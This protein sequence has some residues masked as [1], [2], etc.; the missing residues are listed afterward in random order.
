MTTQDKLPCSGNDSGMPAESSQQ[1][2]LP[3]A[4]SITVGMVG[5][6]PRRRHQ[7]PDKIAKFNDAL[8]RLQARDCKPQAI[9][10]HLAK[11][12]F[13]YSRQ[14]VERWLA[15]DG[16]ASF[17]R[18]HEVYLAVLELA[19][20]VGTGPTKMVPPAQTYASQ[21]QSDVGSPDSRVAKII[22]AGVPMGAELLERIGNIPGLQYPELE[23]A[24]FYNRDEL[25]PI[26]ESPLVRE[27]AIRLARSGWLNPAECGAWSGARWWRELL[28]LQRRLNSGEDDESPSG[29]HPVAPGPKPKQLGPGDR[30]K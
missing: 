3:Q 5:P 24:L 10:D 6:Q 14:G 4:P 18:S 8:R 25:S 13:I 21:S 19:D 16:T 28:A 29:T 30:K 15:T 20:D 26:S 12:E 11:R 23:L 7:S 1:G 22:L 9:V 27:K 17:P 2:Q